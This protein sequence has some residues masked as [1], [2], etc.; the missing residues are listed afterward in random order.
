MLSMLST[1]LSM[2][3]ISLA[4][5]QFGGVHVCCVLWVYA[6]CADQQLVEDGIWCHVVSVAFIV[7]EGRRWS[8]PYTPLYAV[9][10][11]LCGCDVI[12]PIF[13]YQLWMAGT[14]GVGIGVLCCV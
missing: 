8:L 10:T 6:K 5:S 7:L 11:V 9:L 1:Y 3:S 12:M 13:F 2:L 14:F 4:F